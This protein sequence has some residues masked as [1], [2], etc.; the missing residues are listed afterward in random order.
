[1]RPKRQPR[2]IRRDVRVL[3]GRDVRTPAAVDVEV[4]ERGGDAFGETDEPSA[5][6]VIGGELSAAAGEDALLFGSCRGIVVGDGGYVIVI[7][8]ATDQE[9]GTVP[10][11]VSRWASS[12]PTRTSASPT[13]SCPASS[14]EASR[15]PRTER[16]SHPTLQSV[17][18]PEGVALAAD[19]SKLFVT[20]NANNTGPGACH[21]FSTA[22]GALL[23]T[24]QV[25]KT[26][27]SGKF[28][29]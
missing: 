25:G 20:E 9:I 19:H 12:R 4:V 2:S 27:F 14:K 15:Y 23:D 26:P 28:I 24:I 6:P 10:V 21:V 17:G 16:S 7:D 3:G 13:G 29:N 18:Y 5:K 22:T 1:M 11:G 8:Q